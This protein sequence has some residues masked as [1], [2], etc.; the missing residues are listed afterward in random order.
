MLQGHPS[1]FGAQ[2]AAAVATLPYT[3]R[4]YRVGDEFKLGWFVA[5]LIDVE[6]R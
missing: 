5:W 1:W 3:M 6:V 2:Y 4:M